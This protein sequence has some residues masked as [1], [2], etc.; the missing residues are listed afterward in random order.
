[1]S[2]WVP[3]IRRDIFCA[4][5]LCTLA[6][7]GTA[8]AHD[9]YL[10]TLVRQARAQKL[11]RSRTWQVLL[12]YRAMWYG[13]WRSEADGAGFFTA[14]PIGKIDPERELESTLAAFRSRPVAF[15]PKRPEESQHP[16]CRFPARWRFLKD[17]LA[18]DPARFPDQP[19]PLFAMWRQAMAAEKVS[20]VYA[21]AYLNSPA[22]MYGHTFLRLSRA[23]GEGNPL[24][25]YI[26]NFAAD[27]DTDNGLLFAVK[28]LAGG[29][30][31]HFYTM[32]YY[33][34]IQEYSNMESRD[35][36]EYE[37][38]L[39]PE[40]IERLVAHAWETRSTHFDYFFVSENCSY[41]LLGLLEAAVPALHLE[42]R[43]EGFV[44]PADTVRVVLAVPGLVRGVAPRPS[45]HAVMM[46]RK[47]DLEGGEAK[48]A[49]ALAAQ[50][51]VAG[52]LIAG[53][54]PARQAAVVDAAYD[55]LRYKE[56][57][58][59]TERFNRTERDL[60]VLRGRTGEPPHPLVV[61][62]AVDAPERG[63]RSFRVTLG[64]GIG[65]AVDGSTAGFE[66]LAVRLAI[67]DH[68]DAPRGY[69]G[70]AVLEMG[71]FRLRFANDRHDVALERADLI[72]IVS[73]APLDS[74][75]PKLSWSARIG[76]EQEHALGCAGWSCLA[77][78][79]SAGGGLAT[80]LGRALLLYGLVESDL[81]AGVPLSDHYRIGLG[82]SATTVLRLGSFWHTQLGGRY[83]YYFLG[84][85]RRALAA[86]LGQ[87]WNLGT[88][89]QLRAIGEIA[90][91]Y[92]EARL[93]AVAYF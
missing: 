62:P 93:E 42:E 77:G 69:V 20:L 44:I 22:S 49:D 28:G 36:W 57:G 61:A 21:S 83:I 60:L 56:G 41:F 3:R 67:H 18:I 34:K 54:V 74:W 29:F 38:A 88:R 37:L 13:G 66:E 11:A 19:C 24:L 35:L 14:G 51:K 16:Q 33:V 45:L 76:G 70:D 85:R 46:T 80:K 40:Q 64:G 59:D 7:A 6:S 82:G 1:M 15:D 81:A 27:V 84:D 39:T 50:G 12:H 90:G 91:K 75:A 89:A 23:T 5:L 9:E 73:P 53:L 47:A 52:P 4:T 92:R 17:A 63:H 79:A 58:K 55:R 25:D 2:R 32:P 8:A 87:A 65:R 72:H 86:T 68:L 10:G 30:K 31:G 48:A 26:I 71:H 78:G 43:F